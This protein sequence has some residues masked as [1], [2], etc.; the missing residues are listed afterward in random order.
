MAT[1]KSSDQTQ[2]RR[3]LSSDPRRCPACAGTGK[4]GRDQ[5]CSRCGGTGDTLGLHKTPE[6][7]R[8][9]EPDRS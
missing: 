9:C 6:Q 1:S 7:L 5:T 4:N 8:A 2:I 3:R